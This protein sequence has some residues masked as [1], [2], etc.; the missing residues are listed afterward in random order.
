MKAKA[1]AIVDVIPSRHTVEIVVN[2]S[3]CDGDVE[4]SQGELFVE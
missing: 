2:C 3:K 1:M 4:V